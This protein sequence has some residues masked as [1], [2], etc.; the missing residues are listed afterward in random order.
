MLSTIHKDFLRLGSLGRVGHRVAM[1]VCL[2]T[3]LYVIKVEIVNN[4]QS[5]RFFVLLHK[6]EWVCMVLKILNLEE[7]K[8]YMIDSKGKII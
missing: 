1:S 7:N 5:I 6:I 3:C 4:G 8:N 2:C